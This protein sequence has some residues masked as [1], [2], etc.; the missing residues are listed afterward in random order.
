MRSSSAKIGQVRKPVL[1]NIAPEAVLQGLR[2]A[3]ENG[4]VSNEKAW[5]Y[6]WKQV[7]AGMCL[8]FSFHAQIDQRLQKLW[9]RDADCIGF[10]GQQACG[11]HAWQ[12]VDLE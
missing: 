5:A 7:S 11:S 10:L 8:F 12:R 3:Q 9:K 6:R 4:H 1:D 2:Q